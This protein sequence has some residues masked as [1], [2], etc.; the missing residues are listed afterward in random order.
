MDSSKEIRKP[1]FH[2]VLTEQ[3]DIMNLVSMLISSTI[4][5][6]NSM[7]KIK[8]YEKSGKFTFTPIK[9]SV[10][11]SKNTSNNKI[12]I[13]DKLITKYSKKDKKTI[14][15]DV[16]S[17]RH[18]RAT[19]RESLKKSPITKKD[20]NY[21]YYSQYKCKTTKQRK[22]TSKGSGRELKDCNSETEIHDPARSISTE[23]SLHSNISSAYGSDSMESTRNKGYGEASGM[24]SVHTS[25]N[26]PDVVTDDESS[27]SYVTDVS[28]DTCDLGDTLSCDSDDVTPAGSECEPEIPIPLK[29]SGNK[30]SRRVVRKEHT[31]SGVQHVQHV[32]LIPKRKRN[33]SRSNRVS[34]D[35]KSSYAIRNTLSKP[36]SKPI[37]K[38]IAKAISK[39]LCKPISKPYS[40]QTFKPTAKPLAKPISKPDPKSNSVRHASLQ[41]DSKGDV[42]RS[43]QSSGSGNHG[44]KNSKRVKFDDEGSVA[45][46]NDVHKSRDGDTSYWY[47]DMLPE[48][49]VSM[50]G[51]FW[52]K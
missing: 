43:N 29:K 34:D 5:N 16:Q 18:Q 7:M 28:S 12:E 24:A 36:T 4:E 26:K 22:T 1:I 30:S 46:C 50:F 20:T 23:S 31:S 10:H 52:N 49:V 45:A 40:K 15:A 19:R 38:P 21:K 42:V 33:D 32:Q 51:Q 25:R 27:C 3:T 39:P 48:S 2:E 35:R 11:A 9:P 37:S 13:R 44:Y 41:R 17:P 14:I 6:E 8:Y 47:N